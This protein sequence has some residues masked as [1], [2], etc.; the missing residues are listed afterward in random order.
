VAETSKA[1][2]V[3]ALSATL[4]LAAASWVVSVR[5]LG[6]M[7]LGVGSFGPTT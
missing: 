2:I 1:S 7:D 4:G 3:S 5:E 6:G